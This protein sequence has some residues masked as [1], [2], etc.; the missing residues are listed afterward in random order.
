MIRGTKLNNKKNMS[1][2]KKIMEYK[3]PN[4]LYFPLYCY[5]D[6]LYTE[7]NIG[8]YVYKGDVLASNPNNIY[9][10]PIHSSV[11]GYIVDIKNC[12]YID[13]SIKKTIIIENDFRDKERK[14]TGITKKLNSF[15]KSEFVGLLKNA[16]ITGYSG[17]GFPTYLKYNVD[18]NIK[19]LII[20]M[21]ESD[22]Y[23]SCDYAN[24][25]DK[26][27][28]ILE[29]ID[30]IMDIFKIDEC[31]IAVKNFNESTLEDLTDYAGSYPTIHI[32]EV[33]DIYPIGYER[34]LVK[35][36][37][38]VNYVNVPL[39]KG[40]VV[41]NISTIYAIYRL[42]K[43]KKPVTSRVVTVS[44]EGI[45][46]P[47]NI[48][49]KEGTLVKDIINKVGGYKKTKENYN[50]ILGGPMSGNSIS[51][52][53]VMITKSVTG[54]IVI[55]KK[56]EMTRDCI[57]CGKC[58]NICPANLSPF[59]ILKN[60]KINTKKCIGCGLCSYICPSKIDLVNKIKENNKGVK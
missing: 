34:N 36:I 24:L 35:F 43:F 21:C 18:L 51:T 52:D 7:L 13:N 1:L 55:K 38:K 23:L 32:T 12:V 33:P 30:A 26:T 42:L 29:T 14:K 27:Q 47:C 48:L 16:G 25:H 31:F 49:V 57:N 45:K 2:T 17:N 46:K 5:K 39:E 37:K 22:S 9:T 8:D 20:N 50:L 54:I 58:S 3:T 59:L 19:T 60:K 44:G 56:K 10:V 53:E 28:E 40:I 4:F 15:S 41:E 6:N 11:S